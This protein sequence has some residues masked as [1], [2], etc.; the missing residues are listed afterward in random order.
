LLPVCAVDYR[1][2][3]KLQS[4]DGKTPEGFYNCDLAY[5]SSYSFMWINLNNG[6]IEDFGNVGNGCSSFKIC[7]D[8]P[9][10]IDRQ[11]TKKL[12]GN[13]SPG[14]EI[15]IH[16]NCVTA[17]C[18]SFEN[19]N[20][21]PVFLAATFHNKTDFGKIKIHIYPFRFTEA[22]KNNYSE[23]VD[24]EMNKTQLLNFWNEL[25]K[26]YNLFET[27]KKAFSVLYS[28]STYIFKSY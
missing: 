3:T 18:I 8:Y 24:S 20:F 5:G 9:H 17:G 13:A 16:G 7:T 27:N 6:K 19:R 22:N 15:C 26:G 25:E 12:L 10:S 4:G 2:G 14:G 28:D 21:L 11:R 23:S 1:P